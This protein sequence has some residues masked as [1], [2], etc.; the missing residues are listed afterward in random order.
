MAVSRL[1]QSP[2]ERMLEGR[3]AEGLHHVVDR[4]EAGRF[5]AGRFD[6][7]AEDRQP[8]EPLPQSLC[9]PQTR[10]GSR[11]EQ[12]QIGLLALGQLSLTDRSMTEPQDEELKKRPVGRIRINDQDGRHESRVFL[13]RGK[14]A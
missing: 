13:R 3:P 8:Q 1:D 4:R 6:A 9:K 5:L 12:H 2:L 11:L 7:D 10:P 14:T